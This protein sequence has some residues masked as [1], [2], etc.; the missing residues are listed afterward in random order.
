M[1]PYLLQIEENNYFKWDKVFKH[2]PSKICGRDHISRPYPFKFFKGR[3][4]HILLG[5]F[6]NTLSQ[7]GY[8][9]IRTTSIHHMRFAFITE[10]TE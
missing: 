8:T 10:S 5:P 1:L 3:L 9:K 6:L 7:I 4:P 2:E